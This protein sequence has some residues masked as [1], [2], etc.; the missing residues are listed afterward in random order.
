MFY[1]IN[2]AVVLQDGGPGNVI[3]ETLTLDTRSSDLLTKPRVLIEQLLYQR[4]S[5]CIQA[6][7]CALDKRQ[8][9]E[10]VTHNVGLVPDRR[11]SL[12]EAPKKAKA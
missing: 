7:A 3:V 10:N 9:Y 11:A 12:G 5:S 8:K 6:L 4:S 1:D 2:G